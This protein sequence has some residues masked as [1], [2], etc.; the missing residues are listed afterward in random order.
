MLMKLTKKPS[1]R[2]LLKVVTELQSL[3][4]DALGAHYND[5]DP[6]AFHKVKAPLDKALELCV[7]ARSFDPPTDC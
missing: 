5:R 6:N 2:E 4:G 7:H 1:R 3:I